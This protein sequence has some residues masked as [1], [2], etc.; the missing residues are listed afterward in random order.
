[1]MIGR[2]R[3][4]RVAGLIFTLLFAARPPVAGEP[5]DAI[6]G[7]DTA[8]A[9]HR[10]AAR[11]EWPSRLPRDGAWVRYHHD[12]RAFD[13]KVLPSDDTL[14]FVGSVIDDGRR[15]RWVEIKNVLPGEAGERIFITKM[16]ILEAAL[17]DSIDPVS[18]EN[19]VRTWRRKPDGSV[20]KLAEPPRYSIDLLWLPGIGKKMT[21][22]GEK[23]DIDYQRG[24]LKSAT[25]WKAERRDGRTLQGQI[26]I[27]TA[28]D[29][30]VW[31]HHDLP[32]G[33][34][35]AHVHGRLSILGDMKGEMQSDFYLQ[36]AGLDARSELPDHN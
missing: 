14:S 4:I 32:C 10:I 35:E 21:R 25:G 2:A 13:D 27:G 23:K 26:S 36:D 8:D 16:L 20:T 22:T 5:S 11:D 7:D 6:T 1:M 28:I 34:A 29:Y 33:F 31:Q 12:Y 19:V 30:T 24:R 17:L 18:A 3:L 9:E 15:C